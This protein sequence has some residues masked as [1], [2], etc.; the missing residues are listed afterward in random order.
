L[1]TWI[2]LIFG[3]IQLRLQT[4]KLLPKIENDTKTMQTANAVFEKS[5]EK[6][7]PVRTPG[8]GNV[9]TFSQNFRG[10]FNAKGTETVRSPAASR[11]AAHWLAILNNHQPQQDHTAK[12]HGVA[13]LRRRGRREGAFPTLQSVS[14]ECEP[15][16]SRQTGARQEAGMSSE[17]RFFHPLPSRSAACEF[18]GIVRFRQSAQCAPPRRP[19]PKH[20]VRMSERGMVVSKSVPPRTIDQQRQ[21]VRF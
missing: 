18:A 6:S 13:T 20:L 4:A 2:W 14:I 21:V 5:Q 3:A 1:F 10:F 17:P 19:Q 15:P 8:T 11:I 16:A 12:S 7:T 9:T